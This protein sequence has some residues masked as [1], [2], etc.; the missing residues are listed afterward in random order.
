MNGLSSDRISSLT[1]ALQTVSPAMDIQTAYNLERMLYLV[2]GGNT[3][4][5]ARM[6]TGAPSSLFFGRRGRA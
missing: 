1:L 4:A 6:S 5:T 2:T 3:E